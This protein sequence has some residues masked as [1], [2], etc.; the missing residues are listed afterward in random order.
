MILCIQFISYDNQPRLENQNQYPEDGTKLLTT[1]PCCCTLHAF[2]PVP[3]PFFILPV[4][5]TQPECDDGH[6]CIKGSTSPTE[7][8][9]PAG[10]YCEA[11]TEAADDSPCPA[12]TFS[13]ETGLNASS[14]CQTCTLGHYCP[15]GSAAPTNCEP[16]T[17]QPST[18]A[19]D[20]CLDCEAGWA[21]ESAA[22]S[23]MT[24]L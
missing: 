2:P 12:G 16:G 13:G 11:R 18:G 24:T 10:H 8:R 15:A 4:I 3:S 6:Y 9:C 20:A 1:P 17:Y 14:Q 5:L 7:A 22:M 19:M 21:C 23:V